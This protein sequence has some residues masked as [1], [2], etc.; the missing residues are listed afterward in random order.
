MNPKFSYIEG[1]C[2]IGLQL[3]EALQHGHENNIYHGDL[4]PSNI[5]LSI[6]GSPLIVDFNLSHDSESQVQMVG[7]TLPY[8]PPE[9]IRTVILGENTDPVGAECDGPS[10]LRFTDGHFDD[11]VVLSVVVI[12]LC[13]A[14][15]GAAGLPVGSEPFEVGESAFTRIEE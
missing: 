8:M 1:I 13:I 14:G 9:Q 5:V 2:A 7:G 12:D 15:G 4:K 6:I 10:I 3:A 11:D